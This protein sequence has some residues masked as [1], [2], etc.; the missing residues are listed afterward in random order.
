MPFARVPGGRSLARVRRYERFHDYVV[1]V[2]ERDD[3][4]YFSASSLLTVSAVGHVGDDSDHALARG[5]LARV[6]HDQKLHY[7]I[8]YVPEKEEQ[9]CKSVL[10]NHRLICAAH[11]VPVWMM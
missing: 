7:R 2:P 5:A 9:F 3:E 10:A 8:V 4:P 11:F 6:A 1:D